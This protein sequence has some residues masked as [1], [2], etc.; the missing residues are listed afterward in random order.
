MLILSQ[1]N[2]GRKKGL[3]EKL[4]ANDYNMSVGINEDNKQGLTFVDLLELRD[5]V[6]SDVREFILEHLEE[7]RKQV[8]DSSRPSV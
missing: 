3:R 4:D 2:D 6:Q 5:N 7:H 8:G 1:L